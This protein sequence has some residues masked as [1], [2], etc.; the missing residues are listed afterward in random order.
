MPRLKLTQAAVDKLRAPSSGRAE[1]W[2][3]Q[4]PGFGLRI[5]ASPPG[6]IE[7]DGRRTW[8]VM[9]RVKGKLVRETLGT[10]A[11][12]PKIDEA[13]ARARE[14]MQAA[15]SGVNPVEARRTKAVDVA[16]EAQ[17]KEAETFG[18]VAARYLKEYVEKNTR[19]ATIKETRR[20]I[21]RDVKPRWGTTPIRE[22]S[23]REV[24]AL[25]D[26]IA[27]RGALVQANR[28]LARLKTLFSWALDEDLIEGDPT[29][30][31]RGRIKETAR[32]RALSDHEIRLFWAGCDRLGWPFGPMFKLLLLTAQ[33]RDELGTMEWRELDLAARRWTIPRQKAKND[34]AHEVHLPEFALGIIDQLPRISQAR[35]DGRGSEWSPYLFTT[36]GTR[37]VSGFSKAKA[38]LDQHMLHLLRA[39]IEETGTDP[40]KV[41][42][43]GWIL[44]D[45]RR[46]AATGMARLNIA[47]HVVD[48]ILNHVSGTISGVAAVYNRHA[49]LEERKAALETWGRYVESLVRRPPAN[50]VPLVVA[51]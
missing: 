1:Y 22:I 6:R 44:H 37:P 41:E 51:G 21:E 15:Q 26:E 9:Y 43:E 16:K 31:V 24:N 34:R 7:K 19:P 28:T 38:R 10:V 42:I 23:R 49:Y 3:S 50:V 20:I 29:A 30:R 48:R 36:N 5:S 27:D 8:Q 17:T 32:D 4:L 46:T 25:L 35:P 18:A 14:S 39:D 13:R 11:V 47:P 12:I 40:Q 2:D 33:R 45:L